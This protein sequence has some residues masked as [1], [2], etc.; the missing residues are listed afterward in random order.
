[1]HTVRSLESVGHKARARAGCG[2]FAYR[3]IGKEREQ[4]AEALPIGI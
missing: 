2:S 4:D 1:M 3:D